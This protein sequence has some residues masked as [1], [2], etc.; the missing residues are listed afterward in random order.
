[1]ANTDSIQSELS[2]GATVEHLIDVS[3]TLPRPD[4]CYSGCRNLLDGLPRDLLVFYED[5]DLSADQIWSHHRFALVVCLEGPGSVIA[6]GDV[7]Q[8]SPG[9]AVLLFPYQSHHYARFRGKQICWMFVTFE[10]DDEARVG[11]LRGK[12]RRLVQPELDLL[13]RVTQSFASYMRDPKAWA[14]EEMDA[15]AWMALLLRRL[16]VGSQQA[17]TNYDPEMTRLRE[18]LRYIH[19]NLAKPLDAEEIASQA[20]LSLSHLRRLF[21]RRMGTSL[22]AYVRQAR[23]DKASGLLHRSDLTIG[24]V[25]RACGFTSPYVFSRTFRRAMKISPREYRATNARGA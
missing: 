12:K 19:R 14:S 24:Q 10:L 20:H 11:R 1:M 3:R 13:Q 2:S 8:L 21:V 25:A 23:V 6:D 16:T 15:G 17:P 5:R 18:V 4:N 22:G 9:E 7:H